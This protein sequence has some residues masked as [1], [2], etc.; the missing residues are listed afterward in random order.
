MVDCAFGI[1]GFLPLWLARRSAKELEELQR[2][3]WQ[4]AITAS[5]R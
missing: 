4:E 3:S 2:A 1:V 5:G